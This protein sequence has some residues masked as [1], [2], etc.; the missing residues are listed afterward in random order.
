MT[1]TKKIEKIMNYTIKGKSLFVNLLNESEFLSKGIFQNVA[2]EWK[3]L[4]SCEAV[5]LISGR[6]WVGTSGMQSYDL[7]WVYFESNGENQ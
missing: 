2:G 5:D 4:V 6:G 1:E 3:V 7:R